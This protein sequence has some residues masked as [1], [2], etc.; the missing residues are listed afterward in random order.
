MVNYAVVR[1]NTMMIKCKQ[2]GRSSLSSRLDKQPQSKIGKL[3]MMG[4]RIRGAFLFGKQVR[5]RLPDA[6]AVRSSLHE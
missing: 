1:L 5:C 4:N 2:I 3:S 6:K